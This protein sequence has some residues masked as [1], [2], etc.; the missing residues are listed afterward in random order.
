MWDQA[1]GLERE[2]VVGTAL[3]AGKTQGGW[4]GWEQGMVVMPSSR[5]G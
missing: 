4:Q 5:M 2:E 1:T 3:Q